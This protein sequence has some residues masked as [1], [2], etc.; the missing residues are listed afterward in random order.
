MLS[1]HIIQLQHDQA[2]N[3]HKI[4]VWL[5]VVMLLEITFLFE[6]PFYHSLIIIAVHCCVCCRTVY[7]MVQYQHCEHYMSEL[8]CEM[9]KRSAEHRI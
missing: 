3:K 5:L 4:S 9:E 8:D 1:D 2:V 6:L 7:L